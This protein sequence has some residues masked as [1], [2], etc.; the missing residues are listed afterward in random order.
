MKDNTWSFD[1]WAGRYDKIITEDKDIFARYDEVLDRVVEVCKLSKGKRVL[2]IGTGTGNLALRCLSKGADVIGI[3][4]SEPMLAKA[5]KKVK[6]KSQIEFQQVDDPFLANPYPDNYFDAV[7]STYAF[8]HVSHR[9]KPQC[10]GEMIRVLKSGGI[11]ALGDLCFENKE[12]EKQALKKF[13]W[14][15]KDEYFIRIDELSSEFKKLGM[16]MNPKQ[17]TPVVW[18]LWAKKTAR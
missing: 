1:K 10:I 11:W 18:V 15:D 12:K 14:L 8:H 16:K 3:D 7:V 5:R 2:D 6:G 4:P 9:K 17:F 13:D